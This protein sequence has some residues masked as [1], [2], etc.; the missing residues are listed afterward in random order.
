M[1][2]NVNVTIDDL[3]AK[4]TQRIAVLEQENILLEVK[5]EALLKEKKMSQDTPSPLP[6]GNAN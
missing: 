2:E 5:L 1:N 4:F 6:K 3:I